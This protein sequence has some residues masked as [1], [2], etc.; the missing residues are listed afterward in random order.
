MDTSSWATN[1]VGKSPCLNAKWAPLFHTLDD[2]QLWQ[3]E[4][5]ETPL[6]IPEN[7]IA[8]KLIYMRD[9]VEM[10]P[11]EN[12]PLKDAS[13]TLCLV[14]KGPTHGSLILDGT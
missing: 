4:A 13:E 9:E 8:F 2:P 1:S 6:K 11:L 3:E 7:G 12:I 14:K 10:P 5:A